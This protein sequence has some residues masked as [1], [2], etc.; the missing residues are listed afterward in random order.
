[1]KNLTARVIVNEIDGDIYEGDTLEFLAS[2]LDYCN[3]RTTWGVPRKHSPLYSD[4]SLEF[5]TLMV[6]MSDVAIETGFSSAY[7]YTIKETGEGHTVCV[8]PYVYDNEFEELS[9]AIYYSPAFDISDPCDL[10][11]LCDYIGVTFAPSFFE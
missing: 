7:L 2:F 10:K 1:M 8:M 9:P 6:R 4:I 3:E 11:T 5:G